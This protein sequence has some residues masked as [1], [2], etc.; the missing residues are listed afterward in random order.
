MKDGNVTKLVRTEIFH[1]NLFIS[2]SSAGYF[3]KN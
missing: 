2:I 1:N 3:L